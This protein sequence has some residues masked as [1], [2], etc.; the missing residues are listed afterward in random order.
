MNL[1][2]QS[3]DSNNI[4]VGVMAY[5]ISLGPILKITILQESKSFKTTDG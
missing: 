5:Q 4:P 2:Y 3:W 1:N